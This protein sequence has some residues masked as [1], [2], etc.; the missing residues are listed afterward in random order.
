M[1]VDI[2]LPEF[3]RSL[4]A[5][6]AGLDLRLH[7]L[8]LVFFILLAFLIYLYKRRKDG[9]S[10]GFLPWLFPRAVYLHPSHL[11]DIKLFLTGRLLLVTGLFNTVFVQTA[12]GV[13]VVLAGQKLFG[14]SL[15]GA[16]PGPATIALL[17][18]LLVLSADFC[19][20]WIHRIHHEH[21][22]LW[23]FH[24][25]HHS[26]EVLTPVTAYRKHP[27]YDLFSGLFNA[28]VTGTV[29]G[30]VLLLMVGKVELALLGGI[31]AVYF[32]FNLLGSNFRHS[33]IWI[34]Y[35][36]RLEHILISPAQHQIHH[37]LKPAHHNK[38][39]GEIFAVWDWLFGSLYIPA[40]EEKLEFGI[41][42]PGNSGERIAQPHATLRAALVRPFQDSRQAIR[43]RRRTAAKAKLEDD[44][45]TIGES[46]IT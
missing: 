2:K 11:V 18:L 34:S 8:Y 23:P 43:K 38:N 36:P 15:S 28:M 39:Y 32:V 33:H 14:L 44:K 16:A 35:G 25:V 6:A 37:S 22:A 19:V 42:R 30:L 12:F 1:N 17:T 45:N 29:Q 21:P 40:A 24:A 7:P 9:H 13:L 26:A 20:Y 3:A 31:N 46:K 27:V 41:A 10:T 4:L 5:E